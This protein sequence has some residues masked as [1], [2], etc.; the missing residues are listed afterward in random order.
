M[1]Q[2]VPRSLTVAPVWSVPIGGH[3]QAVF[4][5]TNIMAGVT[6]QVRPAL[7]ATPFVTVKQPSAPFTQVA[8]VAAPVVGQ[9]SPAAGVAPHAGSFLHSQ[10]PEAALHA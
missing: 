8:W 4:A 9:K 1:L 10:D 5:G 2:P 7:Q 6:L 3:P